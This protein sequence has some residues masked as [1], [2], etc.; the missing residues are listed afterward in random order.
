MLVLVA[1]HLLL[2]LIRVMETPFFLSTQK[3]ARGS[4]YSGG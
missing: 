1:V 3:G 4:R 2:S